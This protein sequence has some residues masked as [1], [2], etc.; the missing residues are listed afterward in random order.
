LKAPFASIA[1]N[2]SGLNLVLQNGGSA[3]TD[4]DYVSMCDAVSPL[5]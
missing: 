2:D 3:Q 4:G 5:Q 1:R